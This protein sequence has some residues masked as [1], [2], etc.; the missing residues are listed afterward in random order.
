[1][2]SILNILLI[3]LTYQCMTTESNAESGLKFTSVEKPEESKP[4]PV[5][6]KGNLWFINTF[7]LFENNKYDM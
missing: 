2:Y 4:V 5:I 7:L 3:I 1:M 6:E